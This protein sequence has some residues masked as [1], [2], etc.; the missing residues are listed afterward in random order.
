M[1][2]DRELLL[3]ELHAHSTWSDGVFSVPALVD[4]YGGQGF[5]VLCITDHVHA[6]DDPCADSGI[7]PAR[8]EDY[9]AEIERE[10][11][12]SFAEYGLIVVPGVELTFNDEDPDLAA[13]ALAIG[14]RTWA[15]LEDGLERALL[16][17]RDAGAALVAAH[18]TGPA[19]PETPRGATR[20][21]WTE[22]DE[23]GGL[24]D[25]FEL[26]NRHDAYAWVAEAR[27]PAVATGDFHRF[28]HLFTW[29]TLLPCARSEEAV[30][31]C[32]QSDTRLHLAAFGPPESPARVAA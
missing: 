7:P 4:L 25:R 2:G 1:N 24:V 3:S 11:E 8:L 6:A 26:I 31:H 22:L 21:F 32:L 20:R 18:P 9:L 27:L 13:H 16:R 12:R 14:L 5:D 19:S 29:K 10:A 30:V 15:P 17:A 23:L 28:E